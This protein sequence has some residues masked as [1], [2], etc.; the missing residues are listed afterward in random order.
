MEISQVRLSHYVFAI[1]ANQLFRPAFEKVTEEMVSETTYSSLNS[2]FPADWPNLE[3]LILDAYFGS[4]NETSNTTAVEGRQYV[5]SS[6]GL[7]STFSRGN[8][9]ISSPD[10]S[11]NPVISPNWLLDPRDQELAVAAFKRGRDLF[12]TSAIAPVVIEEVYPGAQ[13]QTDEDILQVVLDSANSVYNGAGT[14]KMGKVDDPM[15]VVDSTGR[16]IGAQGLRVVDASIFPFLPPGQPSATVCKWSLASHLAF[17]RHWNAIMKGRNTFSNG[18][19]DM[20]AEK[21][22]D[23]ILNAASN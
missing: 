11:D 2:T 20:L 10:T 21:I 22:A 3:F 9:S 17:S 4:G 14:N 5:A 13:Y 19:P 16:V 12:N 1:L 18:I 23:G 15:A 6:V 8:V 7:V